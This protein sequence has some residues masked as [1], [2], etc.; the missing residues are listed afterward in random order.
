MGGYYAQGDNLLIGRVFIGLTSQH[1]LKNN[2]GLLVKNH[3]NQFLLAEN[4]RLIKQEQF[5]H[6]YDSIGSETVSSFGAKSL[7]IKLPQFCKQLC[8]SRYIR[9]S[10]NVGLEPDGYNFLTLE[11]CFDFCS[12]KINIFQR[13]KKTCKIF[14]Y[15]L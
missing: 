15:R 11:V 5:L 4:K 7:Q 6:R 2:R 8:N 3:R 14:T 12:K 9:L 1:A 13:V 10:K